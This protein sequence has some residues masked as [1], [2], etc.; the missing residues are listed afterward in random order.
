M[1]HQVEHDADVRAARLEWREPVRL[2]EARRGQLVRDGKDHGIEALE[3]A[4][5]QNEPL[6]AGQRDELARLVRRRRDRF[7]DQHVGAGREEIAG[8]SVVQRGRRRDADGVDAADELAM[9]RETRDAE[10][11]LEG[12]ARRGRG[13][14]DTD[15]VAVG[16]GGVFLG[17]ESAEVAGADDG[18]AQSRHVGTV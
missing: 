4:H 18:A 10:L 2:D 16:E 9:V 12:C 15:E 5:L 14:C 13:I 6:A 11:G 1:D 3:V 7:L 17:V 8:N